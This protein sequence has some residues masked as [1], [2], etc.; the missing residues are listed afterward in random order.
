M[1]YWASSTRT[2]E[3]VPSSRTKMAIAPPAATLSDSLA[4]WLTTP[5]KLT[6]GLLS[7]V[8]FP[9]GKPEQPISFGMLEPW[10]FWRHGEADKAVSASHPRLA[11]ALEI[12]EQMADQHPAA[13]S[14][15]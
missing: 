6:G 1:T 4:L 13:K 7:G 2:Q 10:P 8:C 5:A 15:R 3:R 14:D 9:S 11:K 12:A